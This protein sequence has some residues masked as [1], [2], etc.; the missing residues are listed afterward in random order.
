[1]KNSFKALKSAALSLAIIIVLN[2]FF[3]VGLQTFFPGPDYSDFCDD[4]SPV[5]ERIVTDEEGN[6]IIEPIGFDDDYYTK[7]SDAYD[8]ARAAHSYIAFYILGG[9]GILTLVLGLAL[10]TAH[11]VANGLMYGGIL[12]VIIGTLGHWPNMENYEQFIIS[13]IALALLIGLGITK[14]KDH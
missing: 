3:N 5:K 4:R 9:L 11:A 13:G 6:E 10:P 8:E 2:V 7:C 14:L 12:S 1:M